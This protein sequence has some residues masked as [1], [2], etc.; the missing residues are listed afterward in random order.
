MTSSKRNHFPKTPHPSIITLRIRVS[1]MNCRGYS[2]SVH[3][4]V[5]LT[6]FLGLIFCFYHHSHHVD[7]CH[8]LL[9]SIV[10]VMQ[11]EWQN[12]YHNPGL[13][14]PGVIMSSI[15]ANLAFPLLCLAI[16]SNSISQKLNLASYFSQNIHPDILTS[17]IWAINHLVAPQIQPSLKCLF[18]YFTT[19][20]I[21][22]SS[23]VHFVL[24][25]YSY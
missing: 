13:S 25:F 3:N 15:S 18:R 11:Y 1:H 16:S 8:S 5:Y 24:C 14:L 23:I 10:Y 7:H 20:Q 2:H 17:L 4:N 21:Q 12:L 22:S 6:L 19:Y 9:T